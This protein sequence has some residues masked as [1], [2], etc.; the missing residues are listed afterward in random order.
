[1]LPA[2]TS[3]GDRVLDPPHHLDHA[4]GVTVSGVDDE[5][6][7]ARSGERLGTLERVR[8]DAD[9]GTDAQA[10]L[11]V[12]RRL[13]K[14]DLLLD[15]LDRDQ[16]AQPAVGIDDR[17]LLDLVAV[18]DLLRLRERRPHGRGDEVA[19]RHQRRDRLVDVVLEAEVAVREDPD[20]N[21]A[22]VR[23]RDARD[24]VA[25]HQLE[26]RSAPARR[27][28]ASPARRSSPTPTASPCRPRRPAPRSRG[29]GGRC[30]SRL[31]ARARSRGAPRSRCPSRRRRS[32]S[33]ARSRA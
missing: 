19:R 6:V 8:A 21:S 32:G 1:M 23:D 14:L 9:R 17:Q 13:R 11:L 26:R 2:T 12:L 28:A 5:H 18:E 30:R 25:R 16:P 10:A 27:A 24:L 15:V 7:D 31:R 29:C 22:V 3:T 4:L 20:E 33:R